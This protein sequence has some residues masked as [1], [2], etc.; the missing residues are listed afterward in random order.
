MRNISILSFGF[1]LL[2][3]ACTAQPKQAILKADTNPKIPFNPEKYVC[4]QAEKSILVDGVL[5]DQAWQQAPWSNTFVDIEGDLKEKP[6]KESKIKMLWD[7]NYFYIA[8]EL[9]DDHIWGNL[10]EHDA[11]IFNDNDFEVF[12]DPDGDTHNYYEFEIN[13]LNTTWDLILTK[14]YRD[15]GF[16]IDNWEIPGM[17]SAVKIYGSLNNPTDIDDKWTVELAFPWKVLKECNTA[18]AK[19]VDGSQWRINFSRV[20]WITEI[21]DGKYV[22]K[23]DANEKKMPENN[24]VWSPQGVIAMHN[25]ETWGYVQFSSQTE[26]VNFVDN[27]DEEL[28]W[29][30]RQVYYREKAYLE[31]NSCYTDNYEALRLVEVNLNG[32]AFQPEIIVHQTGFVATYP[33]LS[34]QGVWSIQQDGRIWFSKK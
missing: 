16:S 14:P 22:K 28:K 24:W 33:S 15:N 9:K 26:N 11:V 4:Y 27:A 30:L 7:A 19:P 32:D 2:A 31:E 34:E 21:L 20:Q 5:D 10:K 8:A 13:A 23:K 25:P 3:F 6:A 29:A 18:S 1:A 17:K 12:I